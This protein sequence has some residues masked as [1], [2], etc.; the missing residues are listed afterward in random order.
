M[1]E[2]CPRILTNLFP[3]KLFAKLIVLFPAAPVAIFTV[4]VP[5]A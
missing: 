2:L 5:P 3:T 4:E 1:N